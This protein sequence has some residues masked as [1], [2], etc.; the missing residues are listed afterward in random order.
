MY[1]VHVLLFVLL[2]VLCWG[3]YGPLMHEGQHAMQGSL[4]PFICVG[5][6][7]FAIAVLI[8]WLWLVRRGEKGRWTV[9]GVIWST[10]AGAVGALGALGVIM[11]FKFRGSPVYVMPLVFGGAPVVNTV[12]TMFMGRTF[13]EAKP[14][15]YLGVLAVAIGAAGV[16]YFQPRRPQPVR[17]AARFV[18]AVHL[19]RYDPGTV[20]TDSPVPEGTGDATAD[21]AA[22][23]SSAPIPHKT[24]GRNPGDGRSA[25]GPI[26]LSVLAAALCWGSYGPV[27]HRGQMLM[28]G[29]RLRPFLC[30]GVAYFFIAVLVPLGLLRVFQ[31][32]GAWNLLGVAW[33]LAGGAAGAVGAL[34]VI[35]A[36]NHGGRP[37]FVMPLVFGGAP[38]VNTLTTVIREQ[39][40]SYLTVPF[41]VSL[42]V[43]IAGAVTVLVFAP[44]LGHG[45]T[46][47]PAH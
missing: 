6:A 21:T 14:I 37:V 15:F 27:L 38:I 5:F 7:Y 11:A 25:W 40:Y 17:Q 44:R 35:L 19:V 36:F 3:N 34:G 23:T 41:F 43:V 33:S 12:V 42:A 30:V 45:P 9:G 46:A 1:W 32:S 47:S 29:S 8:P 28:D 4:R 16:L 10:L 2:T 13:R 31:E 18:P 22:A 39:T 24:S 20:N 26:L